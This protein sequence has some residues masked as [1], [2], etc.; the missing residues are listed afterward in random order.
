MGR[1]EDKG[2]TKQVLGSEFSLLNYPAE[3][4]LLS[5]VFF[6]PR[7]Q[8]SITPTIGGYLMKVGIIGCGFVGNSTGKRIGGDTNERG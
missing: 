4:C 5:S 1:T 3:F 2:Q 7:L 8:Y 6:F